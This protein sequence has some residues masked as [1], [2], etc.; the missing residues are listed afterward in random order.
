MRGFYVSSIHNIIGL[1]PQ[2]GANTAPAKGSASGKGGLLAFLNLLMGQKAAS[3]QGQDGDLAAKI[4]SVLKNDPS[5]KTQLSA[6]LQKLFPNANA[7][8]LA[9]AV[10]QLEAGPAASGDA[11]ASLT[12]DLSSQLATGAQ[13]NPDLDAQLK[14]KFDAMMQGGDITPDKLAAFR[15]DAINFLK[16]QGLDTFS[17]DKELVSFTADLGST[18]STSQAAQ[19]SMPVPAQAVASA[20]GDDADNDALSG[21]QFSTQQLTQGQAYAN[22][23]ASATAAPG[24]NANQQGLAAKPAA[25]AQ[26]NSG[27]SVAQAQPASTDTPAAKPMPASAA[28]IFVMNNA[29]GDGSFDNSDAGQ[30][31]FQGASAPVSLSAP[32]AGE[33]APQSFVNYM[34]TATTAQATQTAQTVAVQITQNANAGVTSFNMQLEPAELGRLEVRLKF[35]RDGGIKA[36]LI[37]EKPETLAM[38]KQDEGQI[39][40]ILSQAGLNTDDASLSFDLRQQSDHQTNDQTYNDTGSASGI[41]GSAKANDYISAKISVEAMGYIRQD[42]VN[43]MV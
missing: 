14:A 38:L 11:K 1:P 28:H 24:N 26:T 39:H 2:T 10:S 31:M 8:Q 25:S 22:P 7:D 36:H 21:L 9:Q 19:L 15:Q 34:N 30:Q 23:G 16:G 32:I 27:A 4:A 17:I 43:I 6:L 18:L 33:A 13:N 5:D 29:Q 41:S 40:R 35:D 20:N 3:T 12:S 37:A 42:G